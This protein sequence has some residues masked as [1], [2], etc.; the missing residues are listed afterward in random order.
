MPNPTH[1]STTLLLGFFPE[2]KH[3]SSS[4]HQEN[5]EMFAYAEKTP[6]IS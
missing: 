6:I 1:N 4:F 3:N 2:K 5:N